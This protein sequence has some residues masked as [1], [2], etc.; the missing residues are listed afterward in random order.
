[1]KEDQYTFI[2]KAKGLLDIQFLINKIR[3]AK[4][5]ENRYLIHMHYRNGI[6]NQF[7]LFTK[8]GSFKH[9]GGMYIIDQSLADFNKSANAYEL[10]Y[11]QDC[12]YPIQM[13]ISGGRI[14]KEI[15]EIY[16]QKIE[17]GSISEDMIIM[18][19]DPI[20]IQDFITSNV[21]EKTIKG[22]EL[23]E[24][25]KKQLFWTIA[26]FIIL[27]IFFIYMLQKTGAFEQLQGMV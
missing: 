10:T 3:T 11:I 15:T 22:A 13:R 4:T 18:S 16:S 2:Q 26:T 9:K 20:L 1:M 17:D 6:S 8:K 27:A 12:P 14:R 25:L 7:Y 19:I 23:D 21:I 24:A 5:P